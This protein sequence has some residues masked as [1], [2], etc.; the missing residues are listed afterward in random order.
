MVKPIWKE[1]RE[2]EFAQ[3]YRGKILSTD[4]SNLGVQLFKWDK[5]VRDLDFVGAETELRELL[6]TKLTNVAGCWNLPKDPTLKDILKALPKIE[7]HNKR[8]IK[9]W[10]K[11]K[12]RMHHSKIPSGMTLQ[13]S[14]SKTCGQMHFKNGGGKKKPKGLSTKKTKKRVKRIKKGSDALATF[15]IFSPDIKTLE[16]MLR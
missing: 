5:L 14:L 16:D 7:N 13:K 4:Y 12:E 11:W 1:M 2:G 15:G 9:E 10:K 6:G 8:K 3:R